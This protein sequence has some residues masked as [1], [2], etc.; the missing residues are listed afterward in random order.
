MGRKENHFRLE[1]MEAKEKKKMK[2]KKGIGK[3]AGE[4]W[5]SLA[6]SFLLPDG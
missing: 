2:K 1:S 6:R 5:N 3:Y 4:R